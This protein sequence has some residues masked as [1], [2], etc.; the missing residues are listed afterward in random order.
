MCAW[1]IKYDEK[2]GGA[3]LREG[4]GEIGVLDFLNVRYCCSA[5]APEIVTAIEI[6]SS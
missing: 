6:T 1:V 5:D 4:E 2:G 3:P